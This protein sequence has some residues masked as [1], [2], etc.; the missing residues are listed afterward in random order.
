MNVMFS[1]S[2]KS[3]G[4]KADVGDQ[5]P[6][7]GGSDGSFEV[8]CE[9]AAASEPGECPLDHPAARQDLEGLS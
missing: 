4:E 2:C 9:P 1:M 7:L 5:D 8:L 6:C 3:A